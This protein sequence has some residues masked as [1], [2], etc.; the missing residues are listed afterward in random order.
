MA[1]I[2]E[3]I[4][5]VWVAILSLLVITGSG[6]ILLNVHTC[7]THNDQ[8]IQLFSTSGHCGH[9]GTCCLVNHGSSCCS[10]NTTGEP[11]NKHPEWVPV[12]CKD[13]VL[14]LSVSS[15]LTEQSSDKVLKWVFGHVLFEINA[16]C[17]QDGFPRNSWARIGNN[18]C[19][20]PSLSLS[21]ALLCV[22]LI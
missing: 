12:C 11:V 1:G 18:I 9:S 17:S 2:R 20:A 13:Q 19:K 15:F 4:K 22:F 14:Q 5:V 21:P 16:P 10:Q 6:G 8:Y 3:R 7:L